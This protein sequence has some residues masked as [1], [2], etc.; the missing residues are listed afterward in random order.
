[1]IGFDY[2]MDEPNLAGLRMSADEYMALP[3]C[4]KL[5]ELIDGV[6][7]AWPSRSVKHQRAVL[8]IV[9]QLSSYLESNPIGKVVHQVDVRLSDTIVYCPDVI[10]LRNEKAARITDRVNDL[11]DLVIEVVSPLSRACDTITKRHDYAV[12]GVADYWIADP[13]TESV[14]YLVNRN[15]VY[16]ELS[17]RGHRSITTTAVPGFAFDHGLFFRTNF[18]G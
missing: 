14:K 3:E 2:D 4:R 5:Y 8:E 10:F 16:Q 15:S 7:I 13:A 11:P 9:F 1:M 18:K 6:V 17:S 12:A